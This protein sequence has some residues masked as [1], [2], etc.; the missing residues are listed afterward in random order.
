MS[1]DDTNQRREREVQ[2]RI[3][4]CVRQ[5][6]DACPPLNSA[7]REKL[8]LLLRGAGASS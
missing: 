5:L 1:A 7:T 6:V 3:D 8:A 2:A 4:E